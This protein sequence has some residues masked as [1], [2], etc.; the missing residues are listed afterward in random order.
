MTS[1]GPFGE[2]SREYDREPVFP[3]A[4]RDLTLAPV[5]V[6]IDQN[7]HRIRDK[8][9]GE[10]SLNLVLTLN[11]SDDV[12]DR[13]ERERLILEFA[14]KD[15]N[16]HGWTATVTEDAARIHLE[17]GSVT[18]DLGLSASILDYIE[19]GAAAQGKV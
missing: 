9:P 19:H 2:V 15:A 17:G 6:E 16:L 11:S 10:I 3:H 18:I 1:E 4:S 8:T 13:A 14:L 5:A 7:L 12:T